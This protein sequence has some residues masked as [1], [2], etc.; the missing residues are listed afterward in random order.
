M[1]ARE[2]LDTKE[3]LK[4]GYRSPV[5]ETQTTPVRKGATA[6]TAHD[7]ESELVDLIS[8]LSQQMHLAAA[9]LKFE[10]AARLRDEVAELKKELRQLR[11]ATK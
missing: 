6:K 1:L 2:D 3:L 8:E 9:E 7:A 4:G 5:G 11:E 10:M